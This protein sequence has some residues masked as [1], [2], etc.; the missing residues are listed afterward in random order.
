[1][2][3]QL[4]AGSVSGSAFMTKNGRTA[5]FIAERAKGLRYLIVI[6]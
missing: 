3:K 6:P 1:V 4:Q 2:T 5:T